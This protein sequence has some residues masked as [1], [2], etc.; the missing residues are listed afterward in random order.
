MT[1]THRFQIHIFQW[2]VYNELL[3]ASVSRIY[4]L[5]S[6]RKLLWRCLPYIEQFTTCSIS[7]LQGIQYREYVYPNPLR[8]GAGPDAGDADAEAALRALLEGGDDEPTGLSTASGTGILNTASGVLHTMSGGVRPPETSLP[9]S[10]PALLNDPNT[11]HAQ[12]EADA[13]QAQMQHRDASPHNHSYGYNQNRSYIPTTPA[14]VPAAQAPAQSQVNQGGAGA[15]ALALPQQLPPPPPQHQLRLRPQSPSDTEPPVD[16]SAMDSNPREMQGLESITSG[17][18]DTDAGRDHT[19]A[20]FSAQASATYTLSVMSHELHSQG[21]RGTVSTADGSGTIRRPLSGVSAMSS[22]VSAMRSES[23]SRV[24]TAVRGEH[25]RGEHAHPRAV[26]ANASEVADARDGYG[27]A[28]GGYSPGGDAGGVHGRQG[29]ERS[30]NSSRDMSPNSGAPS[31]RE[32]FAL[33]Q[34]QAKQQ[35]QVVRQ[36]AVQGSMT[37]PVRATSS[38]SSL[39]GGA[40]TGRRSPHAAAAL[41]VAQ[42]QVRYRMGVQNGQPGQLQ[43]PLTAP[44]SIMQAANPDTM[45]HAPH[46]PQQ[47][48]LPHQSINQ[49]E[50]SRRFW[51]QSQDALAAAAQGRRLSVGAQLPALQLEAATLSGPGSFREM[52]SA[53]LPGPLSRDRDMGN[54]NSRLYSLPGAGDSA[55]ANESPSCDAIESGGSCITDRSLESNGK[56]FGSEFGWSSVAPSSRGRQ[57][58]GS[59]TSQ[60]KP[61]PLAHVQQKNR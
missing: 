37:M 54:S 36:H 20:E 33:H 23:P 19:S 15:V 29:I 9:Y 18:I 35:K 31:L 22:G 12:G 1:A 24:P 49:D 60:G 32:R 47:H 51:Q 46:A 6:I 41:A 59:A 30:R 61:H 25:A 16:T 40:A 34:Q 2:R 4:I 57:G 38:N 28:Y 58:P 11:L 55:S 43:Q 27:S 13:N 17:A 56:P 7:D 10:I 44:M 53:G 5:T 45:L 50:R 14:D 39:A 42:A 52:L 8:A 21:L 26:L 48:V 3:S